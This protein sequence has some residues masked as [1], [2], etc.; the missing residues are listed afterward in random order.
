[1]DG[2]DEAPPIDL[3]PFGF[4]GFTMF[5]QACMQGPVA[6]N[7]VLTVF[8]DGI[9]PSQFQYRNGSKSENRGFEIGTGWHGARGWSL[10][11]NYSWQDTPVSDGVSMDR[12]VQLAIAENEANLDLDGDGLIADTTDFVNIPAEHRFSFSAQVD[13]GKW[14][15]GLTFDYVDDSFWQDVLTSDFWGWVPDYTLVGLRAGLRLRQSRITLTGQVTNLLGDE[16]QQHIFGDRI[17]RR[18][19]LGMRY[20][21]AGP[22]QA[23]L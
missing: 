13:R 14:Y 5:Q 11:L 22:R 18:V 7:E 23:A 12:R 16:I 10:S 19:T 4:D 3:C 6:Y 20:S 1:M 15:S 21:W 9:I 8:L 17:G 2:I